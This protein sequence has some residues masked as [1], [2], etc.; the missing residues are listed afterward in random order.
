MRQKS[1][2]VQVLNIKIKE[3]TDP[4]DPYRSSLLDLLNHYA[5]F[6][7]EQYNKIRKPSDSAI[8]ISKQ[9]ELEKK[10]FIMSKVDKEKGNIPNAKKVLEG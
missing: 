8:Q 2:L 4:R 10:I 7:P 5:S 6:E 9:L 3:P 1:C